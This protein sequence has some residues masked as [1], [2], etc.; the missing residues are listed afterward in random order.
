METIVEV[1]T[2]ADANSGV[3]GTQ[4]AG[5]SAEISAIPAPLEGQLLQRTFISLVAG[6]PDRYGGEHNAPIIG[7]LINDFAYDKDQA[8]NLAVEKQQQLDKAIADL[9]EQ[10]LANVR[11]EERLAESA[12]SNLVQKICTFFSPVLLSLAVDLFKTNATS[13]Y[14]VGVIGLGLLL[15]NFVPR[16]GKS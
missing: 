13:A 7:A 5:T 4:Q 3:S 8:R 11:L 14:L 16:R 1:P 12:R 2:P 15:T 10:K 6:S 9:N